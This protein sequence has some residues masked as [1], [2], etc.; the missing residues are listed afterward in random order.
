[1][2]ENACRLHTIRI[3][4]N[5]TI[6]HDLSILMAGRVPKMHEVFYTLCASRRRFRE[7]DYEKGLHRNLRAEFGIICLKEGFS[8][9]CQALYVAGPCHKS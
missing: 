8:C 7:S 9:A 3:N 6:G 5:T 1:M 4:V 2:L